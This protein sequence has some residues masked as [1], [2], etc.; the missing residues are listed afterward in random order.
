MRL[1]PAHLLLLAFTPPYLRSHHCVVN[2]HCTQLHASLKGALMS[3]V[4]RGTLHQVTVGKELN[5]LKLLWE[6]N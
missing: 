1:S 3:C 6:N 4:G 5:R 2:L